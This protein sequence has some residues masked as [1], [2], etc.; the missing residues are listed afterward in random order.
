MKVNR[1]N[2]GATPVEVVD[3]VNELVIMVNALTMMCQQL[4]TVA[5]RTTDDQILVESGI[6]PYPEEYRRAA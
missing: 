5:R 3:K 2:Y 6:D 4:Y 1:L